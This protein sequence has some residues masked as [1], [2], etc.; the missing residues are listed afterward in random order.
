MNN[1]KDKIDDDTRLKIAGHYLAGAIGYMLDKL[2]QAVLIV[3]IL[4]SVGEKAFAG[5]KLNVHAK[6]VLHPIPGTNYSR[7]DWVDHNRDEM[8][9][10]S[11]HRWSDDKSYGVLR[12]QYLHSHCTLYHPDENGDMKHSMDFEHS[13]A[14]NK[15]WMHGT[16]VL[17]KGFIMLSEEG[18][19]HWLVRMKENGEMYSTYVEWNEFHWGKDETRLA[20]D[21]PNN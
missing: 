10:F 13:R 3:M 1:I 5:E 16:L 15:M 4:L 11:C 9:A 17:K 2:F 12:I 20:E 19:G 7:V 8:Q 18:G 14:D 6:L 21:D